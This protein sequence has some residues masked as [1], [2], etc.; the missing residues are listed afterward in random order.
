MQRDV[1]MWGYIGCFGEKELPGVA[2]AEGVWNEAT[3]TW[4]VRVRS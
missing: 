3:D 4:S 2:R 1:E